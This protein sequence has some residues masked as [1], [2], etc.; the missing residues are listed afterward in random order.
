MSTVEA[1]PYRITKRERALIELGAKRAAEELAAA[2]APV[3]QD[4]PAPDQPREPWHGLINLPAGTGTTGATYFVGGDTMQPLSVMC[5]LACSAVVAD[6]TVAVEFQD[7]SGVRWLVAG[8]QAVVQASNTQSFCWWV[9]AGDVY[10]PVEDAA[11]APLPAQQ[12]T[13][14]QRLVVKV[15]NGDAGD[16]LDQVRVSASFTP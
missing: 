5:R 15:S 10:W 9:G 6:R 11:I 3:E 2:L 4:A 16:V 13:P 12:L 1:P 7:G 8:T 14:G